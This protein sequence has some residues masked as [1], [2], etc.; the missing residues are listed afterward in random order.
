MRP[1][2]SRVVGFARDDIP[3]VVEKRNDLARS[4]QQH[5]YARGR[6]GAHEGHQI[7]VA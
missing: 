4:C 3:S 6:T 5:H 7:R 1:E 2:G